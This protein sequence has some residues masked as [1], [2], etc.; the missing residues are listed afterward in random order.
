MHHTDMLARDALVQIHIVFADFVKI[1]TSK[2][3]SKCQLYIEQQ[4]V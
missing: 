4:I 3:D 2:H 1:E